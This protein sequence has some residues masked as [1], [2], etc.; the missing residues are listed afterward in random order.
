MFCGTLG[1][2][3]G[4]RPAAA[5]RMALRDPARDREITLEYAVSALPIVA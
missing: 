5:W 2:I 1:A 3:G 4:V